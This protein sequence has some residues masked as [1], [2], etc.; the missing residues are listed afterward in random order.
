MYRKSTAVKNIYIYLPPP[1]CLSVSLSL[2]PFLPPLPLSISVILSI[3]LFPYPVPLSISVF[4]CL[5]PSPHPRLPLTPSPPSTLTLHRPSFT[6]SFNL[7]QSSQKMIGLMPASPG[8]TIL[9]RHRNTADRERGLGEGG[10]RRSG[11]ERGRDDV[12]L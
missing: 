12:M 2:S 9:E 3:S 7:Q 6:K 1:L 8:R 11:K 10:R 5:F 4:V